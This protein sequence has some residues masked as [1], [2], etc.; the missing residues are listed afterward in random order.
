MLKVETKGT[1]NIDFSASGTFS[2]NGK[3]QN[4]TVEFNHDGKT[5]SGEKYINVII[6]TDEKLNKGEYTLMINARNEPITI[7]IPI[8][9]IVV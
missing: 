2:N 1:R 5:I 9:L 4:I 3:L 7:S 8:K 6:D